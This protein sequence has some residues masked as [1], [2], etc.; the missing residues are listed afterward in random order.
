M[1]A[2]L[3]SRTKNELSG[4]AGG[5]VLLQRQCATC[6]GRRRDDEASRKRRLG[7][8]GVLRRREMPGA[9]A[10]AVP[11]VVGEVLRGPGRPLDPGPRA[12]FEPRFGRDFSNVRV[13]TGDRA[14]S[15]AE[16]VGALAYTVGHNLVFGRGQYRP[17]TDSGRRLLAHELTHSMQQGS[18]LHPKL[19]IGDPADRLER[20]AD[21]IADS[22]LGA[23]VPGGAGDLRPSCTP[24]EG[25]A[26]GVLQRTP[27]PPSYG[28]VT[29]VRDLSKI[30]IDAVEDFL[31]S[32]LTAPRTV[33]VHVSDARVKHLT[34]MLYD[35]N[36]R[37]MSGSYSTLP[38]QA[39]STS[40]PFTLRPSHFSGAGFVPGKYILRC[41]GLDAQHRPVVYA[42]RDFNVW[43]ADL[44][45]GTALATTYG[46]L[47]FTKYS[48][49]DANP[50]ARPSYS[51]D[52][53]IS[54]RPKRTVPC[55]DVTYIQA[56]QT[57][58]PQGRS[59]QRTINAEQDARQTP[60][61]WA[62]DR[63]AGAPSPF[64]I[65]GRDPTS[66]ANVDV[67]GWGRAGRGGASPRSATLSDTPRWSQ[68]DVAHFETCAICRS[69]TNRGQAYGCATWGYTA[70]SAGRV[71]LMPRGFRQ[72]PS[73]QFEEARTAW[74]TW[75]ATRPA[76]SRPEAAP[77]LRS[78]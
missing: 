57:N 70:T 29:G 53:E 61:A 64:Y 18:G 21:R 23:Q 16:A 37:M 56:I 14:A 62:V 13:H 3:A 12:F 32:S 59:Q 36:D 66:G 78:P 38:G 24:R 75:R 7:G 34:W 22:V 71:T 10:G 52:V 50:P 77:A 54:F 47:T 39:D 6:G 1:N 26:S 35:P 8:E 40:R 5:P 76:A 63:V 33:N 48:K 17:G 41:S 51:V 15:S 27:A 46:D 25:E 58:D 72:M 65:V 30:R 9:Q 20:E 28:G 43:R 60:L 67:A 49:T 68:E 42:D 45:T 73:D 2:R 44:T 11:P 31:A 74:N 69:G 55:T 4:A 19:R